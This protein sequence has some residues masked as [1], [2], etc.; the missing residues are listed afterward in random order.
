MADSAG[1]RFFMRVTAPIMATAFLVGATVALSTVPA[2]ATKAIAEKE[3]FPCK[4]CHNDPA[5]GKEGGWNAYGLKY[6][7]KIGK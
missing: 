6:K 2:S 1:A 4:K 5:G 7:A 3:G